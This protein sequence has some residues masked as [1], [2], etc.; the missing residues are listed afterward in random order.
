M[1]F[2]ERFLDSNRICVLGTVAFQATER[3]EEFIKSVGQRSYVGASTFP[4]V[5]YPAAFSYK[6][7]TILLRR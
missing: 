2:Y 1:Y 3:K 6:S 7:S 5:G 4:R